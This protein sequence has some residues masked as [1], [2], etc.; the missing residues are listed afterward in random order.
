MHQVSRD[1]SLGNDVYRITQETTLLR[2]PKCTVT[3]QGGALAVPIYIQER[4]AGYVLCGRGR[5]SLDAIIET[6]RGAVGKPIVRELDK[7]F[8]MLIGKEGAAPPIS[9]ATSEDFSKVGYRNAK[10]F[11]EI[12]LDTC[13]RFFFEGNTSCCR[14]KSLFAFPQNN[15]FEILVSSHEGTTYVA[16]DRVYVLRGDKQVLKGPREVVVAKHGKLMVVKDGQ[17]LVE[18]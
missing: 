5:F 7:P 1:V 14:D 6:S 11:I 3:I 16:K 2:S 18:K 9:P 12:A 8:I 13:E 15:K 17:I 4:P 10:E